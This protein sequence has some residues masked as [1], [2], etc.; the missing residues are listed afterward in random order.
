MAGAKVGV[1]KKK[2]SLIGEHYYEE[3]STEFW[4]EPGIYFVI[5]FFRS[6]I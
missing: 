6:C 4:K 2:R 3:F 1:K 5:F